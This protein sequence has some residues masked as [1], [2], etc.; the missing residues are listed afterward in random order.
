MIGIA[1]P[2]AVLGT[3]F[4]RAYNN[5]YNVAVQLEEK[6]KERMTTALRKSSKHRT[7]PLKRKGTAAL[8][9]F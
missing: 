6:R 8:K 9:N 3:E 5:H 2:V 7:S 4:T 1:I